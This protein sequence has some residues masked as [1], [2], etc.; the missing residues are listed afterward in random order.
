LSGSALEVTM[1]ALLKILVF[2]AA[3]FQT[4]IWVN[5]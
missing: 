1:Y 3:P 2:Q 5:R 4:N